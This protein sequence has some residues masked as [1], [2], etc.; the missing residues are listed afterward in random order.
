[1]PLPLVA[2]P[3]R[4]PSVSALDPNASS[5]VSLLRGDNIREL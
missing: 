2:R 1:L 4:P 5:P 3:S